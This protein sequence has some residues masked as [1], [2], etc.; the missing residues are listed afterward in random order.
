MINYPAKYIIIQ[1]CP[2]R[3]RMETKN[4]GIWMYMLDPSVESD[5]IPS[6]ISGS[7][8]MVGVELNERVGRDNKDSRFEMMLKGLQNRINKV[9]TLPEVEQ[10]IKRQAGDIN[11]IEPRSCKIDVININ[12]NDL[13]IL[14]LKQAIYDLYDEYVK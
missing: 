3:G 2:D 7:R 10:I 1:Y 13:L 6:V 9:K 5:E 14:D 8:V 11:F 12:D 4:I